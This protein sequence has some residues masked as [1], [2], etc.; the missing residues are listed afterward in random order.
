MKI[1]FSVFSGLGS[2]FQIFP[3]TVNWGSETVPLL[4]SGLVH[5][6]LCFPCKFFIHHLLR[7]FYV[8]PRKDKI[9]LST[10][11]AKELMSLENF[12]FV[13]TY[14]LLLWR[15]I[16][17]CNWCNIVSSHKCLT[18]TSQTFCTR[19]FNRK[20]ITVFGGIFWNWGPCLFCVDVARILKLSP[21][22]CSGCAR[23][24]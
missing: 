18:Y 20:L 24:I 22:W 23:P 2:I 8:C 9:G 4:P 21:Y 15:S 12:C 19:S 13:F 16:V 10:F 17:T 5:L 7:P 11:E 3:L 14:N 1:I 6:L